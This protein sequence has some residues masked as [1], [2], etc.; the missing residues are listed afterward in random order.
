VYVAVAVLWMWNV[1]GVRPDRWD[2][3]GSAVALLGMAIIVLG[4]RNA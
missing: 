4:P 2:L 1:D 3:I